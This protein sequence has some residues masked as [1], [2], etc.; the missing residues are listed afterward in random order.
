M[1]F[2]IAL[3]F[4][5]IINLLI[6]I[7]DKSRGANL[8]GQWAMKLDKKMVYHFWKKG[9]D[10]SRVLFV[11]GTNGKSTTN[12]LINHIFKENGKKVVSNLE[13]ANLIFGVATAL[14]KASSLTGKIDTDFFIFET[15]ERYMPLIRKQIPAANILIT[16]LQK[17]QV[18]RN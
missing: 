5:K 14:I 17:D 8:A 12:N 9:I 10:C 6:S 11:T 16:N 4:G 2:I 15:D 7:I 18:Q 13:G 1:K 3:W